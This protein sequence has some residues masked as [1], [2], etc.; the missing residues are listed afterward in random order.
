MEVH[1]VSGEELQK[2]AERTINQPPNCTRET[3]HL[4]KHIPGTLDFSLRLK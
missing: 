2:L 1:P 3:R 4:G